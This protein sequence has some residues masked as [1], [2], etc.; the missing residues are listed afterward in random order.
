MRSRVTRNE[1]HN[2][3]L[4]SHGNET[5][6]LQLQG[7][8][9][10]GTAHSLLETIKHEFK[11]NPKINFI[12]LDFKQVN[13][14][15]ATALLSFSKIIRLI[16]ENNAE[17]IISDLSETLKDSFKPLEQENLQF[18][19]NLDFA[20]E[21]SEI[22]LLKDY[23]EEQAK[24]G[25]RERLLQLE[26]NKE[27]VDKLISYF[28]KLEYETGDYLMRQGDEANDVI[29]I[30]SGQVT[31]KLET[32]DAF[33]F[34]TMQGGSVVGELGFYSD[35]A[36]TASV[37]ADELTVAY[38][39][40]KAQLEQMTEEAPK[41]ATLFHRLNAHLLSDRT[42]HLMNAVTALRR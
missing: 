33:R 13:G 22:E 14:L 40:T 17:L 6:I 26:P 28:E 4:S 11:E 27:Q 10:F 5:F 36:R 24:F 38:K 32:P 1:S 15:D 39:L 8:I 18:A 41:S 42:T 7:Y 21:H 30:E 12:I 23:R 34:E 19:Q 9:F 2:R 3:Y 25:L 31:A 20:L 37:I 35:A 29:F 16:K